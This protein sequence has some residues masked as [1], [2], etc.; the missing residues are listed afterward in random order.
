MDGVGGHRLHPQPLH[1]LVDAADFHDVTEDQ[2]ALA[3]G[4]AGIDDAVDVLAFGEFEDLFEAGFGV[5]NRV[6]VEA[7]RDGGQHLEIPRQFFAVGAHRHP[8]LDQMTDRRGDHRLV[9]F[10]VNIAAGAGFVEFAERFGQRPAEVGHDAG[11]LGDDEYFSHDESGPWCGH[12][13]RD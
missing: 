13:L 3:A 6:E 12:G 2:L 7:L 11:F 1:G 5:G 4:I 8:Q 9:V 10:V